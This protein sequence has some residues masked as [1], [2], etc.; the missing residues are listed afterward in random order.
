MIFPRRIKSS[1]SRTHE[2]TANKAGKAADCVDIDAA[3]IVAEVDFW[4]KIEKLLRVEKET[5]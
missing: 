3:G 1:K 4:G 5:I 2:N